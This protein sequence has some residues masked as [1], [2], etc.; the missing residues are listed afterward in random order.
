MELLHE[1]SDAVDSKSTPY[2]MQLIR[3]N[4]PYDTA[5]DKF[6]VVYIIF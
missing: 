3:Q 5:I 1:K 2:V 4:E 6:H